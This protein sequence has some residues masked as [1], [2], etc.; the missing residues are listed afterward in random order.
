MFDRNL[1]LSI[2]MQ[3][4][5]ALQKI[6]DRAR[7][8]RSADD[9]TASPSGME[10][11]DSICMLFIAVGEARQK[12]DRTHSVRLGNERLCCPVNLLSKFR[13]LPV[14]I[15]QVFQRENRSAHN[16]CP[17]QSPAHDVKY[18]V[19]NCPAVLNIPTNDHL[20]TSYLLPSCR[21][22]KTLQVSVSDFG[23]PFV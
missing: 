14:L 15:L 1:V 20:V 21:I 7:R 8:F 18:C 2:L 17:K 13:E 22:P 10:T 19:E 16:G 23:E 5:A 3:I 9:F 6:A 11:L 12:T 4:D